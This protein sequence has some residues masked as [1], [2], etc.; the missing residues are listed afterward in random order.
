MINVLSAPFSKMLPYFM[1]DCAIICCFYEAWPS[2][3]LRISLR[4]RI[5]HVWV[6]DA[7]SKSP[8]IRSSWCNPWQDNWSSLIFRWLGAYAFASFLLP[9]N[10]PSKL[11]IKLP[12]ARDIWF[13]GHP[14]LCWSARSDCWGW[15][16]TWA[17]F[18]TRDNSELK[19]LRWLHFLSLREEKV[20]GL[21][22]KAFALPVIEVLGWLAWT[23]EEK[24]P[25]EA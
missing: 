6:W 12:S 1:V 16:F 21:K 20:A 17:A 10:A 11:K 3:A 13:R 25:N 18:D 7:G 23:P 19:I 15:Y 5:K 2:S 4:N 24:Q 8:Q 14:F 9:R 22:L